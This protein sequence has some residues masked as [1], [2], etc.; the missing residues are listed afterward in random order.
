MKSPM[1]DVL[2]DKPRESY[3]LSME[4]GRLLRPVPVPQEAW[5]AFDDVAMNQ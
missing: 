2:R 3:V 5:R 4:V 1:G